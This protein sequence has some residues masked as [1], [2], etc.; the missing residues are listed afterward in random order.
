MSMKHNFEIGHPYGEIPNWITFPPFPEKARN[1]THAHKQLLAF[2][3]RCIVSQYF[4]RNV[5]N[6][7][8]RESLPLLYEELQESIFS[9]CRLYLK[10][11][12][13]NDEEDEEILVSAYP[14]YRNCQSLAGDINNSLHKYRRAMRKIREKIAES[15]ENKECIEDQ[16]HVE[17][18]RNY[19]YDNDPLKVVEF[20]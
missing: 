6:Q 5:H 12:K 16:R 4:L 7:I 17:C 3:D 20:K 9:V 13:S 10:V 11:W 8:L 15:C 19:D 18:I 1:V 2:I 14:I